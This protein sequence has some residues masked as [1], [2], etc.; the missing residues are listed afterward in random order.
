VAVPEIYANLWQAKAILMEDVGDIS[1]QKF[2]ENVKKPAIY[3]EVIDSLLFLQSAPFRSELPVII[4]KSVFDFDR[5]KAESGQFFLHFIRERLKMDFDDEYFTDDCLRLAGAIAAQPRVLMHRD[6]QSKNIFIKDE[7]IRVLD[8]QELCMGPYTYDLAALLED[9]YV[10]IDEREINN[11]L[12][13]YLK[14]LS[15]F[16]FILLDENNAEQAFSLHYRDSAISRLMQAIGAFARL[17]AAGKT[18][19]EKYI[20][21]AFTK[22]LSRL[23]NSEYRALYALCIKIAQKVYRTS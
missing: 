21:P 18:D 1:L 3:Q 11:Y 9:P 7:I 5:L 15:N 20:E 22:L 23:E 16:G 12:M 10:T 2:L 4:E 13:Y 6:F 8:F 17:S 14:N 19:F